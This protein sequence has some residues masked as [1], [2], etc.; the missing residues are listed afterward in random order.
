[1]PRLDAIVINNLKLYAFNVKYFKSFEE[2]G[3]NLFE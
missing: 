3:L 1:M 2:Y